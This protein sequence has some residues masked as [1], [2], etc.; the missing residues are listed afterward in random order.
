[1]L[2]NYK[3]GREASVI[4]M[5]AG[6]IIVAIM[7]AVWLAIFSPY[8]D[9][10]HGEEFVPLY[11]LYIVALIIVALQFA[12]NFFSNG[13]LI[14]YRWFQTIQLI[15]FFCSLIFFG[16]LICYTYELKGGNEQRWTWFLV[17]IA[18][19]GIGL[20][21]EFISYIVLIYSLAEDSEAYRKE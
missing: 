13:R 7:C 16:I 21:V 5:D 8:F 9:G 3:S 2:S 15:F 1:M 11:V 10:S 4:I 14:S 19:I 17:T 12:F 6:L 18:V 20:I